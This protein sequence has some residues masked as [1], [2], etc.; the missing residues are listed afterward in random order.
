[1]KIRLKDRIRLNNAIWR[2]WHIECELTPIKTEIDPLL[3]ISINYLKKFRRPQINHPES[4]ETK[5]YSIH[6]AIRFDIR[7]RQET[8]SDFIGGRLLEKTEQSRRLRVPVL[9]K[10][11]LE[12]GS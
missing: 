1:M 12:T 5:I 7:K 2:C 6:H 10:V 3:R 11:L 9:A 8:S 4:N